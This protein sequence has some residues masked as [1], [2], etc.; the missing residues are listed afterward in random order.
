MVLSDDAGDGLVTASPTW[1]ITNAQQALFDERG[2]WGHVA[3]LQRLGFTVVPAVFDPATVSRLRETILRLAVPVPQRSSEAPVWPLFDAAPLVADVLLDE[4]VL[5]FADLVCGKGLLVSM[6]GLVRTEHSEP[7]G[8]HAENAAWLPSPYARHN[9]I[10]SV[11][12]TCDDV[13][14]PAGGTGFVA[15]SH[16]TGTD[17]TVEGALEH[18]GVVVPSAPAGSLVVWLGGT[19]HG[20]D[21]RRVDGERV[22][23]LSIFGRPSLRPGQDLRSI[24]ITAHDRADELALRLGRLDGFERRPG[25]RPRN[26]RATIQWTRGLPEGPGSVTVEWGGSIVPPSG[27]RRAR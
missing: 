22:S 14:E 23:L 10:C 25:E 2:W 3:E 13:D 18:G 24:D 27:G 26:G 4:A 11:M 12:V 19:W 8:L 6:K 1:V 16:L 9:F 5:A 7:L 20:V 17:P 15:G 21:R